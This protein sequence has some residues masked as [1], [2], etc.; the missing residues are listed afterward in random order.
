MTGPQP[1][2]G[3]KVAPCCQEHRQ[4]RN[5]NCVPW[6][7]SMTVILA[8]LVVYCTSTSWAAQPQSTSKIPAAAHS[9]QSVNSKQKPPTD[10]GKGPAK[11]PPK[12][13]EKPFRPAELGYV[14]FVENQPQLLTQKL[15]A[16][17][18]Q[19]LTLN[20]TIN[21]LADITNSNFAIGWPSLKSA[22]I[23]IHAK[24]SVA[25]RA[26]SCRRALVDILQVFAPHKRLVVS[27]DENVIFITTE[28]QD[29]KHLILRTYWLPDILANLPRI[30]RP[31]SILQRLRHPQKKAKG[32]GFS[33]PGYTPGTAEKK[34]GPPIST[35]IITL[36]TNAVRPKIWANHGGNATITVVGNKVMIDA[37]ASVQA[38]LAGPSHYNPN[39]VPRYFMIGL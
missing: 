2:K 37:P 39:A 11:V 31:A 16:I 17:K 15:P 30:I 35:N 12:K 1:V 5:R 26:E 10:N 34:K 38:L 29:D 6:K 22:G 8:G 33:P 27:A 4:N 21:R 24:K 23:P 20:Q 28:A 14:I 32:K 3:H 7:L 25:L 9:S 19:G 13:A 18:F 36:I